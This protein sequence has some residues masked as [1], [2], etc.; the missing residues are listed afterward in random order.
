MSARIGAALERSIGL[1]AASLS[2]GPGAPSV[3]VPV[4]P[5]ARICP[6]YPCGLALV[7]PPIA[8][9]PPVGD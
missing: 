7:L 4:K 3:R 8:G 2:D 9:R 6:M 5:L 1:V